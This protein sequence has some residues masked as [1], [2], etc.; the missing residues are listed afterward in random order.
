MLA[1]RDEH[2]LLRDKRLVFGGEFEVEL[3]ELGNWDPRLA[4]KFS[5]THFEPGT[6]AIILRGFKTSTEFDANSPLENDL[7]GRE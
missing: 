6:N 3:P 5:P 1:A 7:H 2:S 4:G